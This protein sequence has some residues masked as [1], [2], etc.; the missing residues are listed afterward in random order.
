MDTFERF[1]NMLEFSEDEIRAQLP[2]WKTACELLGLSEEDV[3]IATDERIPKY[4]DMSLSG[5]RKCIGAYIRELIQLFYLPEYKAKGA[6]IL[7]CNIPAHPA[8]IFANKIS[9]GDGIHISHPDY[10]MAS[11]LNA[12]FQKSTV[13]PGTENSCMNPMCHHCGMNRIR[14]DAQKNGIIATPTVAWNWGLYCDE[15]PKIEELIN[16][17]G[18][19]DWNSVLTTIPHDT[20]MGIS[21]AD[22]D[23]RVTYL[24]KR[25]REGQSQ[26]SQYTSIPVTDEHLAEAAD[27]YYKYMLKLETLTNMVANSDPQP[28]NGNELTLFGVATALAFDTGLKYLN[29]AIDEIIIEVKGRVERGEGTLPAGS[30]KLACHFIPFCV[31]WVNKAFI[32]NG[33]NICINTFFAQ[34]STRK[35]SFETTDIYKV[36]ARQWF[37]NPGAVNMRNE[38]E[39]VSK[40]L[41]NYP[42]DGAL[43]GFFSFDRWV[44]GLQKTMIQVVESLTGIPHYYLEGNFWNDGNVDLADR[45]ARIQNISYRVKIDHMVNKGSNGKRKSTEQ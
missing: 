9:G 13:L 42:I 3:R 4:W 36:I 22:D 10:F 11:V 15:G 44:G 18:E 16:C 26:V 28:I 5:V 34:A 8:C 20:S 2:Q 45:I 31:P 23:E 39:L 41:L 27:Q 29:E 1:L 19:G 21:E 40:A 17:L 30:P 12:F 35:E 7:Y 43:Y 14:V 24:A 37:N 32:D 33:V 38:A 6:K 25:L